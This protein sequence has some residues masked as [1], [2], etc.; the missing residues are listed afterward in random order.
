LTSKIPFREIGWDFF[1]AQ[2]FAQL[3]RPFGQYPHQFGK[4]GCNY[5]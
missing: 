5:S 2:A 1:V 3:H 4:T